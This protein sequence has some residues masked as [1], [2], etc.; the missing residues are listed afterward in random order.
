LTRF[1][2]ADDETLLGLLSRSIGAADPV[3]EEAVATAKV[4]AHLSGAD[5]ELAA[6]V[7]DS[8]LD[9]EVMLFRHDVTMEQHGQMSDRLITFAT[10]ELHVDVDLHANGAS[11]VGAITP[12]MPVNVEL[13][14]A[15]A[16]V[17]TRS[18]ELGRFHFDAPA[19]RCRLRIH[20][21]DGSVVTPWITR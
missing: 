12:A 15:A 19:G 5:A 6:L 2:L 8:L 13:E 17:T 1:D 7:A 11:L 20:A 18:D 16:T 4:L 14:T 10:P 3:P 21:H 9:D